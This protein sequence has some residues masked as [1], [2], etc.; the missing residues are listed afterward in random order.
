MSI[1]DT[2][3]LAAALEGG[4]VPAQ[5]GF[6]SF[7]G[8]LINNAKTVFDQPELREAFMLMCAA[9]TG[10]RT[11]AGMDIP[12]AFS[13]FI[14]TAASKL[15]KWI[16]NASAEAVGDTV[17]DN[18]R[19]LDAL[20]TILGNENREAKNTR[21]DRAPIMLGILTGSKEELERN[22]HAEPRVPL[23]NSL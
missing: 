8:C 1:A 5:V 6:P 10:L 17:N 11:G 15:A 21:E 7:A 19:L 20:D 2:D 16:R 12:P 22:S 23:G 3:A 4:D 9:A 13:T 14:S 18:T